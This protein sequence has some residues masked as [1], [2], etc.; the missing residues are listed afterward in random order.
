MLNSMIRGFW[1]LCVHTGCQALVTVATSYKCTQCHFDH[2][3]RL[4]QRIH[5]ETE[6]TKRE[7]NPWFNSKFKIP[8]KKRQ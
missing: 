8:K 2:W 5:R 7:P 4:G 1:I 6:I 3:V